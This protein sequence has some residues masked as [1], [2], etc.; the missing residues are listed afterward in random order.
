MRF[1]GYWVEGTGTSVTVRSCAFDDTELSESSDWKEAHQNEDPA[2][3]HG[4]VEPLA[5]LREVCRRVLDGQPTD[6]NFPEPS[7]DA[8]AVKIDNA[9]QLARLVLRVVGAEAERGKQDG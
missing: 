9:E 7:E 6:L 4:Y 5:M 8:A 3:R 2:T 1:P